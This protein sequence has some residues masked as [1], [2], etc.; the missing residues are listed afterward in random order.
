MRVSSVF[1]GVTVSELATSQ[2]WYE[3]LFSRAP[4]VLVSTEEVMWQMNDSAWLFIV[5]GETCERSANVLLAVEDLDD[6]LDALDGRGI[7]ARDVE[8]IDGAGRKA[9]FD[10]PDGNEVVI[11]EIYASEQH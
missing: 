4:D 8:V 1:V 9:Y 3:Q 11:A 2:R 10:D 5:E 6:A 7:A